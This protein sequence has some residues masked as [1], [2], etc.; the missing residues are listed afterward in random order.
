[1]FLF[2]ID[3]V[4]S[5]LMAGGVGTLI[6]GGGAFWPYTQDWVRFLLS[7]V[8]LVALIWFIYYLSNRK[9]KK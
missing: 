3:V 8:G 1:M 7:L 5:G 4:G 2:G 6:Y 9:G